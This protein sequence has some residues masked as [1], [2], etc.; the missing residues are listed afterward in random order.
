MD[1]FKS[2]DS[3]TERIGADPRLLGLFDRL[4]I[5]DDRFRVGARKPKPWHGRVQDSYSLAIY[6]PCLGRKL[7]SASNGG[8]QGSV[9]ECY[10]AYLLRLQPRGNRKHE[11]SVR[12]ATTVLLLKKH[13]LQ[14]EIFVILAGEIGINRIARG[15]AGAVTSDACGDALTADAA[16]CDRLAALDGKRAL[17]GRNPR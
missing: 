7:F 17:L 15:G 14:D 12:T 16:G 3:Q 6:A 4:Q 1:D 9:V 11:A 8:G 2:R 10:I 5:S 13:Q